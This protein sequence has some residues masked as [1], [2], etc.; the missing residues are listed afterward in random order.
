MKR[1]IPA[2][3]VICSSC[4]T[5]P[6]DTEATRKVV[7]KYVHHGVGTEGPFSKGAQRQLAGLAEQD[8]SAVVAL[9]EHGAV[10]FLVLEP[11]PTLP[12]RVIVV[13]KGKVVG[14]YPVPR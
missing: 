6:S 7:L 12:N 13:S 3:L 1:L 10:G 5:A 11:T 4:A 2:L 9:L 8:R 14:D